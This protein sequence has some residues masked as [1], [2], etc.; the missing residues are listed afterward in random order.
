ML[1]PSL[2]I[3][4]LTGAGPVSLPIHNN[5][6]SYANSPAPQQ[7][8]PA[9]SKA[10]APDPFASLIQPTSGTTTPQMNQGSSKT[11]ISTSGG[12]LDISSLSISPA[13]GTSA[14]VNKT[15][16][17]TKAAPADDEWTF[18]SALPEPAPQ[19]SNKI[20]V[21][22]SPVKIDFVSERKGAEPVIHVVAFFSNTTNLPI[23]E[24]HFQ[25]AIEKVRLIGAY[26]F[27]VYKLCC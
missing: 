4:E 20:E 16:E 1:V 7:Q 25:V 3:D 21:L 5:P 18:A 26:T 6:Q 10:P 2:L 17:Q 19:P 11:P 14:T 23:S 13:Q 8:P 12:L 24:L 9:T 22:N 27:I 15:Q